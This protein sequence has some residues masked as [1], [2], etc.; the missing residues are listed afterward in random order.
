MT[1][2]AKQYGISEELVH[3]TTLLWERIAPTGMLNNPKDCDEEAMRT[4]ESW[5]IKQLQAIAKEREE[6]SPL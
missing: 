5:L 3:Q 1:S 4:L 6:R 2:I